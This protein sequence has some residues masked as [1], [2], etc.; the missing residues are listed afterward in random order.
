MALKVRALGPFPFDSE[1]D[2]LQHFYN[3]QLDELTCHK[4]PSPPPGMNPPSYLYNGRI[5]QQM[6]SLQTI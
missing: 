5:N 4:G 3:V 1:L 6:Y 2:P